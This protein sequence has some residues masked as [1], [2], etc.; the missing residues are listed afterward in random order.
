[1]ID[2]PNI[3]GPLTPPTANGRPLAVFVL[4]CGKGKVAKALIEGGASLVVI[5]EPDEA[6]MKE[7]LEAAD[8]SALQANPNV[9][10]AVGEPIAQRIADALPEAS[11]PLLEVEHGVGVVAG[12]ISTR[13]RA[14]FDRAATEASHTF[15]RAAEAQAATARS[16][17]EGPLRLATATSTSTSALRT[18]APA[19]M[20]AAGRAGHDAHVLLADH[21]RDPFL[22]SDHK[23]WMLKTNP[24]ACVSFLRPGAMLAPWRRDYPSLVVVS[25][26]PQLLNVDAMPWSER[27]LVVV[28]DP[29]FAETYTRL[30]VE[31]RVRSLAT[32][33][34][35]AESL[36]GGTPCDVL[37][38]G[39]VP[40]GATIDQAF[41]DRTTAIRW[42]NDPSS[43][44]SN[45]R[46]L[47]Y[48]ATARRRVVAAVTL[49]KEGFDV[50]IHGG[51]EWVPLIA[52]TAA[53][54]C[55][56]GPLDPVHDQAAAFAAA[57]CV[58]NVNSFATPGMVNMRTFD[59]PAAGGVLIS[60]DRPAVHAAFEV[61]REVL[62]F[63]RPEELPEL[64]RSITDRSIGTAGRA[65]VEREHTWDHWWK[66]AEVEL[67]A[68]RS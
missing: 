53:E 47:A 48:E 25:S 44:A 24:D 41:D 35:P 23:Q 13:V 2:E 59:V 3:A 11:N 9:R 62:V 49:A 4:G 8:W 33:V 14:A 63:S 37:I 46:A 57:R 54:G 29:A 28:S 18:L 52:G 32:D 66:W 36:Q 26:N 6:I 20:A 50:R 27:E 15:D 42:A 22:A 61:G 31:T 40:G 7:S 38:V 1:M 17:P 12:E 10:F 30:G 34:P 45:D 67:R 58:I 68:F 51:P 39:N 64:V 16:F 21:L 65:R 5:V 55:W 56:F 19:I 60:D 43:V